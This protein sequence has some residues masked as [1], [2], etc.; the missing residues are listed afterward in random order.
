DT[1]IK[2]PRRTS[3]TVGALMIGLSFV[4]SN[5][6]FIQSQKS[7]L[8]RYMDRAL[9]A[10]IFVTTSEQ[11]RSR[12]YH[13]SEE[14]AQ[15]IA[16][17]PGVKHAESFRF[18]SVPY[19]GDSVALIAND[20]SAWFARIGSILDEGDEQR[21]RELMPKGEGFLIASN[22]AVRWG[23]RVGDTLRIET[24]AGPLE[25]RVLGIFEN[26]DS[27]KGT[28][29]M[30][31]ALYKS[32]WKDTAVDYI[33]LNLN[34]GIDRGA[35]K[36]EIQR[37]IAGEQRAFIYTNEEYKQWVMKLIDQ[38]FMLTYAQMFVA[39][40]VAALG[41]INTLFISV[42]ERKREIGVIRAI[43][44]LRRQVRKMILLEAVAIAI[45]GV[46]TGALAGLFNAYF[47]VRTA[48]TIIA[49]FTLPLHFP[50]TLILLTLPLVL[51]VAL[52]AAWWPAQRAVRLRVIE[53]IGYE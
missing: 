16:A 2:S 31:R 24:P 19:G 38:F 51:L 15:R 29:F 5:G 20:M 43:G 21:A 22:F 37:A 46:A 32:Y 50:T 40:L 30:D 49:G 4:F 18:T 36:N 7:A 35:F 11:L 17:I 48:A 53:A 6:A 28:I 13:F 26:Y 12:T 33:F 47:L 23:A 3:A 41:I 34:Q 42:S 52:A 45:I 39:I 25:R 1:M 10:D 27:E 9:N 8:K 44:G 14:L